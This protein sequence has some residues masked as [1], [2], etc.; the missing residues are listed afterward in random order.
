MGT[1]DTWELFQAGEEPRDVR[2]EVLTSWRRSRISGVD[3][4]YVDVPYLETDLD[5]HFARV[6]V[7]MIERRA[8]A[9]IGPGD[10]GKRPMGQ[11]LFAPVENGEGGVTKGDV[12]IN[13]LRVRGLPPQ[14]GCLQPFVFA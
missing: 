12:D 11:R 4:E 3:P 6:A 7:G 8:L 13:A 14:A 2:A 9:R 1:V 10:G 5:S